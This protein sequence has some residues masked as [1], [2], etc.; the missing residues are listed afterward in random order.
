MD[1]HP[2]Q[3]ENTT[4]SLQYQYDKDN[5]F[6]SVQLSIQQVLLKT[7]VPA[8][9]SIW[10]NSLTFSSHEMRISPYSPDNVTSVI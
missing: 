7:F 5:H 10:L 3:I 8:W 1:I 6:Q 2:N 4:K 9:I